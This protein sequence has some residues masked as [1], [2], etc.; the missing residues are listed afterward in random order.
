[1]TSHENGFQAAPGVIY[2]AAKGEVLIIHLA[3][4]S[5]YALNLLGSLVWNRLIEGDSL[6]TILDRLAATDAA[7][8]AELVGAAKEFVAQLESE[9][10]L[11]PVR[12]A[13]A[14]PATDAEFER[15]VAAGLPTFQ[16]FTDMADV[17]LADP[18]HEID[19]TRASES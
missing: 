1:M 10:L 4:G 16:R 12:S 9:G 18:V 8:S 13:G 3:F 2:E 5:Y 6:D 7:R 14:A 17:L 19:L 15:C 11:L